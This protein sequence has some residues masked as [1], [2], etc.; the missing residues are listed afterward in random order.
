[1][2]T[3][4]QLYHNSV[5]PVSNEFIFL[6]FFSNFGK[7]D[8]KFNIFKGLQFVELTYSIANARVEHMKLTSFL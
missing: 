6:A 3:T 2:H 8:L 1:M 4:E 7:T 5:F